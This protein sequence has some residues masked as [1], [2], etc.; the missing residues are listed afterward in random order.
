MSRPRL[1]AL[2]AGKARILELRC[3]CPLLL[4][5][6]V[7]NVPEHTSASAQQHSLEPSPSAL[8]MPRPRKPRLAYLRAVSRGK[9]VRQQRAGRAGLLGT[10][11]CW[12]G[13]VVAEQC[14]LT[15]SC[16][17]RCG[18]PRPAPHTPS[19]TAESKSRL[20]NL[21]GSSSLGDL[22]GA[23][24]LNLGLVVRVAHHHLAKSTEGQSKVCGLNGRCLGR[25]GAAQPSEAE[26]TQACGASG[27]SRMLGRAGAAGRGSQTRHPLAHL[28]G[29]LH[30]A[31]HFPGLG[32]LRGRGKRMNE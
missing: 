21:K 19:S 27:S 10:T 31:L 20:G 3:N 14:P 11:P 2:T 30:D 18:A 4:V 16:R 22:L 15:H 29:T 24:L 17:G 23:L 5:S 1:Q 6:A 8:A 28:G 26:C 13:A 25:S 7:L 9:A 32:V 12:Q